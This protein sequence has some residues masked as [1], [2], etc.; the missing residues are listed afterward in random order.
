MTDIADL[1]GLSGRDIDKGAH[2]LSRTLALSFQPH[3]STFWGDYYLA[4]NS[5]WSE[6]LRLL[7]NFNQT[8]NAW[9]KP[10]FQKYPLI[11]EVSVPSPARAREIES[12]L[13]NTRELGAVL[14]RRK[15]YPRK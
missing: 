7:E 12:K 11:L 4:R 1:Y 13:L 8:T 6:Q 10:E 15:E 3:E 9:N 5:D 2:V 14:L